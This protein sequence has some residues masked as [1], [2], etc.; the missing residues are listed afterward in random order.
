M[1]ATQSVP[2]AGGDICRLH[3]TDKRACQADPR[4]QRFHHHCVQRPASAPSCTAMSRTACRR[5]PHC[6]MTARQCIRKDPKHLQPALYRNSPVWV[7]HPSQFDPAHYIIQYPNG[8]RASVPMVQVHV[9]GAPVPRRPHGTARAAQ[10]RRSAARAAQR[11][12]KEAEQALAEQALAEQAHLRVVAEA[13][14]RKLQSYRVH[15]AASKQP[16]CSR[17]AWGDQF[18]QLIGEGSCADDGRCT[19]SNCHERCAMQPERTLAQWEAKQRCVQR[20]RR[21]VDGGRA[22]DGR[23]TVR[24]WRQAAKA[25]CR[26]RCRALRTTAAPGTQ[27]R[28]QQED[29]KRRCYSNCRSRAQ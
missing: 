11:R 3:G 16:S 19:G 27:R 24:R 20:C 18:C 5:S 21:A 22:V 10:R 6:Q 28:R 25:K 7:V 13:V 23:D 9:A 17:D 15:S 14:A 4:C 26:E 2:L 8:I 12:K 29:M 1:G